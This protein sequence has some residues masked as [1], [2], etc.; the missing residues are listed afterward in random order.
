[1]SKP[2]KYTP[3]PDYQYQPPEYPEGHVIKPATPMGLSA[4]RVKKTSSSQVTTNRREQV[5]L[6]LG[7]R[8]PHQIFKPSLVPD[9]AH[10]TKPWPWKVKAKNRKHRKATGR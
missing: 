9:T 1:V 3:N 2:N 7:Y 8:K 5:G 4:R 6:A 10:F